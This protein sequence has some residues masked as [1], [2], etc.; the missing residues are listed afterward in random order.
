MAH[1]QPWREYLKTVSYKDAIP[2]F[3]GVLDGIGSKQNFTLKDLQNT[4]SNPLLDE[5][6]FE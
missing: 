1:G 6:F 4:F 3:M 5:I 2:R